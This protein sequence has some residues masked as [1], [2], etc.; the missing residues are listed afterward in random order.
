MNI[1]KLG[2]LAAALLCAAPASA[3]ETK[4]VGGVV[5][6]VYG[7]APA[8]DDCKPEDKHWCSHTT[9][10]TMK[11]DVPITRQPVA[12]CSVFDNSGRQLG[13]KGAVVRESSD[14]DVTYIWLAH[15]VIGGPQMWYGS[16]Q[17]DVALDQVARVECEAHAVQ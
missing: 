12:T 17:L 5:R 3:I 13:T 16:F 2:A 9:F 15:E 7:P 4:A 14:D 6:T 8:L 10:I 11:I 1:I